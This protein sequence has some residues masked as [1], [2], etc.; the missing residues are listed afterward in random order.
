MAI[1]TLEYTKLMAPKLNQQVVRESTSGWMEDNATKLGEPIYKGGK[2]VK[3]PTISTTG[4]GDY[5]RDKGFNRT[6]KVTLE[7]TP[8]TMTQDRATSFQLDAMDV[9]ETNFVA[10]SGAV[11]KDFQTRNV[12]PELDAYRYSALAA[13]AKTATQS[14][15]VTLTVDTALNKFRE[16]VDAIRDYVGQEMPLLCTLPSAVLRLIEGNKEFTKQFDVANFEQGKISLRLKVLD[17]VFFRVVPSQRLWDKYIFATGET[18][19]GFKADTDGGAKEI[20]WLICP[21]E[22]PV[23]ISRT[24]TLRV[25]DPMINQGAHAWKIDYRKYHDL[26]VLKNDLKALM[27]CT[28]A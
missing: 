21:R 25:F 8:Y 23:A 11:I 19:W 22:L 20:N 26:W 28:K 16:H 13:K 9:A 17:N 2:E 10:N 18:D 5:D 7:Y 12:I 15:A 14:E 24:D 6:G 1:N 3:L 4:L 27:A